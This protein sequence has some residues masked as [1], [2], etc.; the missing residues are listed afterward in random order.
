MPV[1]MWDISVS[2]RVY[3]FF[4]NVSFLCRL[5]GNSGCSLFWSCTVQAGQHGKVAA[6]YAAQSAG[7]R[8]DRHCS[9]RWSNDLFNE[10][11]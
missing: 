5:P 10:V 9:H 1:A 4:L 8:R 6:G 3:C 2:V 7:T 11:L